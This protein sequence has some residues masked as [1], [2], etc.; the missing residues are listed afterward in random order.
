MSP[1]GGDFKN[2]NIITKNTKS[3]SSDSH[4]DLAKRPLTFGNLRFF[5]DSPK[6]AFSSQLVQ[7]MKISLGSFIPLWSHL[8]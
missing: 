4:S 3:K 6:E 8:L 1:T 7:G 5:K 2:H